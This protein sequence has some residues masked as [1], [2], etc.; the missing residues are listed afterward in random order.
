[1][2]LVPCRW[3]RTGWKYVEVDPKEHKF[4]GNPNRANSHGIP[5]QGSPQKAQ[6]ARAVN[7]DAFRT[8]NNHFYA[9]D[10]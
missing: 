1:M 10:K 8:T 4:F 7:D 9:S 6:Q 5:M 3:S 2:K